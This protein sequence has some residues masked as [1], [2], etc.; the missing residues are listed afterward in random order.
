MGVEAHKVEVTSRPHG[1]GHQVVGTVDGREV[2]S[3]HQRVDGVWMVGGSCSLPSD[4]V[5]AEAYLSCM[6]QVMGK[7]RELGGQ[8]GG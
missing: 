5:R 6:Q 3:M 4:A 8:M 2:M 1:S 7:A